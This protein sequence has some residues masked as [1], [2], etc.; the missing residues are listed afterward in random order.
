M[1][2]R[3]HW[4]C[5]RESDVSL[6]TADEPTKSRSVLHDRLIGIELPELATT[7]VF[8]TLKKS[9]ACFNVANESNRQCVSTNELSNSLPGHGA[10]RLAKTPLRG[11]STE[12]IVNCSG[13][14]QWS[15]LFM[16]CQSR[17]VVGLP[18]DRASVCRLLGAA[19]PAQSI[20]F[21]L[22]N[23]RRILSTSDAAENPYH[24]FSR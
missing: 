11:A 15:E 13:G 5:Q 21:L 20:V 17:F 22:R 12:L 2:T 14:E 23:A 24:C 4:R 7:S 6:S 16:F 9:R 1:V 8:F 10:Q 19:R 18:R 3:V